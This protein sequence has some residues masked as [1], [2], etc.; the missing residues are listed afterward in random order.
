MYILRR[1][2]EAFLRVLAKFRSDSLCGTS[3]LSTSSWEAL[4]TDRTIINSRDRN[5]QMDSNHRKCPRSFLYCNFISSKKL[6]SSLYIPTSIWAKRVRELCK[7]FEPCTPKSTYPS[8]W[9]WDTISSVTL[10]QGDWL[11]LSLLRL[12]KESRNVVRYIGSVAVRGR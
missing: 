3:L 11:S 4:G 6:L 5:I 9:L 7:R 1:L 12:R 10:R 8:K 2:Q